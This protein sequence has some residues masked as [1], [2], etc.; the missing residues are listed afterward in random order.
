MIRKSESQWTECLPYLLQRHLW[1]NKK[2]RVLILRG[3]VNEVLNP[4]F[5]ACINAYAGC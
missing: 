4:N 2:V 3:S 5:G 1:A